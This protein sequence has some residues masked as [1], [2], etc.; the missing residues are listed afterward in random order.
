V[1]SIVLDRYF[2]VWRY[3]VGHSRLLLHSRASDADS[4][5]LNV[6]F[7]DVRAVKLHTSYQPLVLRPA[8]DLARAEMLTFAGIPARHQ[9]RYLSLTLPSPP[10]EAGFI[11]CARATVLAV[12]T[13][14]DQSLIDH[15]WPTGARTVHVLQNQDRVN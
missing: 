13:I 9:H 14:D 3:G 10:G 1:D 8:D 15:F 5:H 7:E 6:L 4:D 12:S 2:R 11:L